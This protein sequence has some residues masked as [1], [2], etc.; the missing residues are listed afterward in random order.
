[1]QVLSANRALS[2][3]NVWNN[4]IGPFRSRPRTAIAD[5]GPAGRPAG[6]LAAHAPTLDPFSVFG[7]LGA[8]GATALALALR[9]NQVPPAARAAALVAYSLSP[10]VSE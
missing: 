6:W 9:E 8:E 4:D 1:V 7:G 3:L 10:R 5:C 2:D